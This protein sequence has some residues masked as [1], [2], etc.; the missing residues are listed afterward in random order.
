MTS[1]VVSF[2]IVRHHYGNTSY[3]PP[4]C[5]PVIMRHFFPTAAIVLSYSDTHNVYRISLHDL[6]VHS[7]SSSPSI[8]NW[9]FNRPPDVNRCI[10]IARHVYNH[11]D[12]PVDSLFY[13]SYDNL[14]NTFQIIDGIHRI[15]AL[16]HIFRENSKQMTPEELHT[17]EFGGNH[18]AAQ[19]FHKHNLLVNIRFNA[20]H[21]VLEDAFRSLNKSIPVSE[22]YIV[23]HS[24]EKRECIEKIVKEW[25]TKYKRHFTT[26]INPSCGNTNVT[27]FEELLLHLYDAH[28]VRYT[29]PDKL[30]TMLDTWNQYIAHNI[31]KHASLAA[32][33]RCNETGCFL[34]MWKTEML[35]MMISNNAH[36]TI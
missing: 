2:D 22:L 30:K 11:L 5:I 3:V 15:T 1:T 13:A 32:R 34:F 24:K 33:T 17:S 29:N 6:M 23:D 8:V 25:T 20:T 7:T 19:W 27:K 31:P 35:E 36:P 21:G 16:S 12:T 26:S 14:T 4:Y 28:L 18:S 10:E 9:E